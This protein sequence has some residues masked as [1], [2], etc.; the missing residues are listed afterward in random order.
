MKY[1]LGICNLIGVIFLGYVMSLCFRHSVAAEADY[2][3]Q[4]NKYRTEDAAQ[5]CYVSLW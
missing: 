5:V 1:I 3:A 4:A 2:E